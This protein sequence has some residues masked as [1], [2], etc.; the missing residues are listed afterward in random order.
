VNEAI[1]VVRNLDIRSEVLEALA[2][3]IVARRS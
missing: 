2:G 1:A 3:F